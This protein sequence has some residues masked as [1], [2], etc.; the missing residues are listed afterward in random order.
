MHTSRYYILI[1]GEPVQCPD[2]LAWAEWFER[3]DRTLARTTI[4]PSEVSTIFLGL[5]H[6]FAGFGPPVLWETMIFGGPLAGEQ[7]RYTSAT[8]ARAGHD[9]YVALLQMAAHLEK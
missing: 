3:S 5:D 8:A 1:D 2:L 4:G 6:D 9:H 7:K